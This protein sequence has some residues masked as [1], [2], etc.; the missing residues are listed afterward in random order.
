MERGERRDLASFL[1]GVVVEALVDAAV[2]VGVVLLD[3]HVERLAAFRHYARVGVLKG[4]R[5]A[6]QH[7]TT[8]GDGLLDLLG[9]TTRR[10]ERLVLRSRRKATPTLKA[11]PEREHR[12][13]RARREKM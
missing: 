5:H 10:V 9:A 11:S 8:L 2:D 4:F 7:L 13:R 1:T 3:E 6:A 12:Q